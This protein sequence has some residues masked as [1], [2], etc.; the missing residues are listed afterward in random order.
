LGLAN[1]NVW[2]YFQDEETN[3]GEDTILGII[4]F[5]ID[6]NDKYLVGNGIIL[7]PL[8][9]ENTTIQSTRNNQD[10]K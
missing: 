5:I 6:S 4:E 7:Y 3:V 8:D 9:F 10:R 1:K 2:I